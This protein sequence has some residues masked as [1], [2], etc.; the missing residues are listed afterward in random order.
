M[1]PEPE[2]WGDPRSAKRIQRGIKAG[3]CLQQTLA[4]CAAPITTGYGKSC[5]TITLTRAAAPGGVS[6]PLTSPLI[7]SLA[8]GTSNGPQPDPQACVPSHR[9]GSS[10]PWLCLGCFRLHFRNLKPG[11]RLT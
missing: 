10:Q 11:S 9:P 5:H 3:Q 6:Y 4:V 7:C 8:M 2:M 1:W